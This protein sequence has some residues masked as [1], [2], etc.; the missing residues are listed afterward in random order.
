MSRRRVLIVETQ[1]KQYRLRF[2]QE[3]GARLAEQDVDLKILYSAAHGQ[4][5]AKRDTVELDDGLGIKVP[6]V[7]LLGGRVL[8]QPVWRHAR[9]ADLVITEQGNKLLFN[10]VLLLLSQL[11]VKRIAFWGHGYNHQ[12]RGRSVSEWLKR[13]LVRRVD[14]WFAYTDGVARYLVEQGV[15]PDTIS[16]L[17]NTIDTTELANALAAID[18]GARAAT[19]EQLGIPHGAR[20]GLFCGSL[21]ADKKLGFLLEAAREVHARIPGF[22]LIIVGD[23][24]DRPRVER[25]ARELSYVHYVGATF[26]AARAAYFAN[27]DVFMMPGLVGLAVVDAFASGLPVLTTDVPLHGPEIEYV[28]DGVNGVMTRHDPQAYAQAT[29]EVLSDETRLHAM[30]DAALAT[31]RGLTLDHMV[32]AFARG[33]LQAL[34]ART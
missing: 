3:L 18:P 7:W 25:A 8:I 13:K 24:P 10:Y 29:I 17:Q 11:G 20:V 9:D 6:T 23:G 21:Y 26:G 16:V 12:A 5:R 15:D 1:I 32:D 34:Q 22:H 27:A 31:A 28:R 19:R 14:W 30:R 4:E 33:V 2:F